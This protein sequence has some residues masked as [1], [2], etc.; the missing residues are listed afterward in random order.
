[1][2]GPTLW[3]VNRGT[4]VVLL[5]VVTASIVLGVLATTRAGSRWWPRFLTQGLHRNLGLLSVVLTLAH[6]GSAVADE[7][8]DIRWWQAL[9][10]FGATYQPFWLA[11]GTLAFDLTVAASLTSLLRHRMRHGVWRAVHLT[12]WAVFGLGVVHGLGIG[13]DAV[14]PW[15]L[16]VTTTC[17]VAVGLAALLRLV[18]V[19][20]PADDA[21]EPTLAVP[22]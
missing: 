20:R 2:N 18:T 21:S 4:G 17:L 7:Y 15:S 10:P 8:V 22:R 13:T 6:A 5:A 3:F 14:E 9:V 19:Q 16:A 11:L 1:M 12:T